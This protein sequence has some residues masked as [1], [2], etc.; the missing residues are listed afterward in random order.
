MLR[1]HPVTAP[2]HRVPRPDQL[3]S[4]RVSDLQEGRRTNTPAASRLKTT[5]ACLELL[6]ICDPISENGRFQPTEVEALNTWLAAYGS[7]AFIPQEQIVA[8]IRRVLS[9]GVIT[10][11]ERVTLRSAVD[12]LLPPDTREVVRGGRTKGPSRRAPDDVPIDSYRF[13]VAG[14]REGERAMQL[15]RY[16]FEGDEVLLVRDPKNTRSRSAAI[17]RLLAGFE[18]GY[19]PELDARTMAPHLDENLPYM[20]TIKR[21]VRGGHAPILVVNAEFFRGEARVDGTRRPRDRVG[22]AALAHL[23]TPQS[24][25]KA[26]ADSSAN[27][28]AFL[29]IGL[30]ALFAVLLLMYL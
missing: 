22:S 29:L 4:V 13:I 16:A 24:R 26:R 21:V 1:S 19:V 27:Y 7:A 30:I 9:V 10:D 2:G 11:S 17:V 6:A 8:T 5:E 3:P 20:A 28:R 12:R 14:S 25:G 15:A 23:T 18:V